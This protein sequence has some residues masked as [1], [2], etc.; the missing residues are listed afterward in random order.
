MKSLLALVAE[1]FIEQVCPLVTVPEV[2]SHP[3]LT[4]GDGGTEWTPGGG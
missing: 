4:V 3:V 1:L 2:A